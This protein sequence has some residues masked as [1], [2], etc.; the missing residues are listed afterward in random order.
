MRVRAVNDV[1]CSAWTAPVAL[2]CDAPEWGGGGEWEEVTLADEE[3]LT[4]KKLKKLVV[5]TCVGDGGEADVVG[6]ATR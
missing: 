3:E 1:G 4:N 5:R 2:D 6:G